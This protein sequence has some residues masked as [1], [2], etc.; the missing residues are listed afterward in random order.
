MIKMIICT[1]ANSLT[2]YLLRI[3]PVAHLFQN[4]L[5]AFLARGGLQTGAEL[6]A[7]DNIIRTLSIN[8]LYHEKEAREIN[9]RLHST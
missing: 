9:Q 5:A 2:V 3:L 7:P 4:F 8:V 6:W 1:N